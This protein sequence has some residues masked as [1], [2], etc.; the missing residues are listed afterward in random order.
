MITMNA[1]LKK[2]LVMPAITA[3]LLSLAFANMKI[4]F[5]NG[6][7]GK[8]DLFTQKEPYSGK[9]PNMPSDAFDLQ[10]VVILYAL[11]T[12]N[13]TPMQ[14]LPVA[15]HVK[16]PNNTSFSLTAKTNSSGIATVDFVIP[17]K[18]V[19][20]T[21]A[22]GSWVALA[23]VSID[24]RVFEDTLTFR[25]DRIVKLISV[26]TMDQ[27]LTYR[28][29]FGIGGDVGLEITLRSVAMV[30]KSATL[31]I[32]IQD[33]LN[34]PVN[35]SELRDIKVTP[36]E[37]LV[38]LHVS[39]GIPKY[40][41]VGKAKAIVSALT[42][43]V[44]QSGV[45]YCLAVS[46]GF[47]IVP[48]EPLTIA[49][50]DVAVVDAIPSAE[51]VEAGQPVDVVTVVQNEGT[52]TESFG[53]SAY[54]DSMLI[55]TLQITALA[56]YSHKTLNFTFD[57]S[58]VSPGNYTITVSIPLL[59]NE[60]DIS[61]NVF[62]DGII[63]IKPK[64]PVVFHDIAVVDVKISKEIL[65]I[66][67]ALQINV[68][69]LN[70][71]TE[72]ETFGVSAYYDSWQIDTLQVS[73]LAP[74]TRVTLV[75][76]WNTS[77]VPEGFYLISA[78][79]PLLND[80]NVVDNTFVNGIVQLIARPPFPP[81]HDVAVLSVSPS[82]TLVH[83]GEVV[84]IYVVVKNEG[85]YVE[86]F[87]VTAF[88]D[89]NVVGRL[90]VN[91]LQSG[92]EIPLVFYW[93]TRSVAE[94]NFTLSAEASAVS[95]ELNI[96]DNRFVDGV[97]WVKSWVFPPV[98]E[99]PRWLLALLFISTILIGACIVAAIVFALLR[100]RKRK[101]KDQRGRQPSSFEVEPCKEVGFKR[102]KT[103]SVCGKEFLGVYTFCPYCFTFHGKDY[104]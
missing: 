68:T 17:Q 85:S 31:A 7:G 91:G 22:F 8:I 87:D 32:V 49:F 41:F 59:V 35:S 69:V 37:K 11:V 15:F 38:F 64:K 28:T 44:N 43:P 94:G 74:N 84:S 50:H 92:S 25:V 29:S 75:F 6:A 46:A 95:G 63:R 39:L 12:Y 42:A 10:E 21:E 96:E 86:S 54:Y 51:T 66:G 26:R 45:P 97:V 73:A 79:A 67:E 102:S 3:I 34:V 14:N 90:F 30:L 47:F 24:S 93:N 1:K 36:N 76:V 53:V 40:A 88:Y 65:Y 89:S 4:A 101:R 56:L 60:A 23:N 27:N 80:I 71:G 5:S 20:E 19:N 33:E 81:I 83:I 100:R 13:E 98:W 48:F 103:C 58:T 70:K 16:T 72:T 57:T 55:G 9:G 2:L 99:I 104:E 52:T 78:S 18:C 61:D 82:K 62:V 77:F